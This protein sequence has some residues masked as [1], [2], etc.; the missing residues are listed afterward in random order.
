MLQRETLLRAPDTSTRAV[1]ALHEGN[2]QVLFMAEATEVV[3]T[4]CDVQPTGCRRVHPST[5]VRRIG[6]LL[7]SPA[8]V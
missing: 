3:Y 5:A 6:A 4:M 8:A 1:L 7:P 2:W